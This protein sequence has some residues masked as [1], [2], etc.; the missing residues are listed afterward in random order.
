[1][2]MTGGHLTHKPYYSSHVSK[3]GIKCGDC[4]GRQETHG[5]P[6]AWQEVSGSPPHTHTPSKG[7]GASDHCMWRVALN[8]EEVNSDPI[9]AWPSWGQDRHHQQYREQ[10]QQKGRELGKKPSSD[11]R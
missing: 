5:P 9:I 1:M 6:L 2:T 11:G 4:G 8:T 3:D 7:A 10:T